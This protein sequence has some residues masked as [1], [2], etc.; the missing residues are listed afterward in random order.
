MVIADTRA[1]GVKKVSSPKMF[2]SLSTLTVFIVLAAAVL[3]LPGFAPKVEAGEAAVTS[4]DVPALAKGDRL[5]ARAASCSTQIWPDFTA[6]CLRN[7]GSGVR[8][9][10]ARVVTGRR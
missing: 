6:S 1:V 7:A 5:D 4:K 2:K 8:I 10:E 9:Q 3:A